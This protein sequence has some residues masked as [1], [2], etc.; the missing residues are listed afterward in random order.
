MATNTFQRLRLIDRI[1]AGE[2]SKGAA[3]LLALIERR[4]TG[5]WFEATGEFLAVCLKASRRSV[6]RWLAELRGG[7]FLHVWRRSAVRNGVRVAAPSRYRVNAQAVC[8]AAAADCDQRAAGLRARCVAALQRVLRAKQR[9]AIC[10]NLAQSKDQVDI[11]MLWR[12][13]GEAREGSSGW[14]AAVDA[15]IEAGQGTERADFVGM[16]AV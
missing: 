14:C 6:V 2:M 11:R 3:A 5:R 10:A 7:G 8:D 12:K 9:P 16:G 13:V 4:A 1:D 15:L